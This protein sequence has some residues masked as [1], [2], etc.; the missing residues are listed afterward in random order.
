MRSTTAATSRKKLR[1]TTAATWPSCAPRPRAPAWC[2]AR[3]R[4]AWRAATTPSAT[5]TRCS[6]CPDRIEA[7][8]MPQVELIDMRE[9]FLET[10][11]QATFSRRWWTPSAHRMENGEQTI[12]LLNR[13][14]FSSFV[15]CRSCGERVQCINC[16]RHADL[17]PPRPPPALPLLRLRREGARACVPSA[18]A[19]T[20][21]SSASAPKRWKRSC[22]ANFRRRASP[23]WIA[24]P[25][26]ASAS[27]RPSCRASARAIY[28]ILVGTQMIA[29][30]HDIPNVTLVGVV[31]ADVGLGMPDFRAAE[32]TF[33]LLTQVAGRAGRGNL[34]GHR[35]DPDHQSRSLRRPHGRGPGLS[36][37]L[38]K[39]TAISAA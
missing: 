39:G 38:R 13:R 10:R 23:A 36:G 33:Q 18:R 15:A 29:K 6:N 5:S 30:G 35:A 24:T 26:P 14:G 12:V 11:K 28:D 20:S 19:S 4:P 16:S 2:W 9:E 21:I 37:V 7:R 32:R 25:S 34:P 1:A 22:T 3:P 31:S 17:P 8:P 27:T